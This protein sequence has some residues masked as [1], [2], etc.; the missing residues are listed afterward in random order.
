MKDFRAVLGVAPDAAQDEIKKAYRKLALQ[1]HPD[2][3]GDEEKFKEITEAYENLSGK[4]KPKQPPISYPDIDFSQIFR[5]FAGFKPFANAQPQRPPSKEEQIFAQFQ[6][7]IADIK[8]GRV[9][10]VN[11][12]QSEDCQSCSGLGG[13]GVKKN[14]VVC[15]GAGFQTTVNQQGSFSYASTNKCSVCNGEGK[16]YEK[17]CNDCSGRGWKIFKKRIDFEIKEKK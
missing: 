4:V 15:K 2:K 5:E 8:Q 6:I 14:C 9:A 17:V 7:S 1:H 3:G 10:H 12:N 16:T 13:E 11:Y